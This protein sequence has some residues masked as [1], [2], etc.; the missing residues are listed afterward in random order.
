MAQRMVVEQGNPADGSLLAVLHP[1]LA[2]V[3]SQ[4]PSLSAWR[5]LAGVVEAFVK[6]CEPQEDLRHAEQTLAWEQLD[7]AAFWLGYAVVDARSAAA[8]WEVVRSLLQERYTQGDLSCAPLLQCA[9]ER[10]ERATEAA[11]AISAQVAA[12]CG[13]Y[14]LSLPERALG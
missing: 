8:R 4:E 13:Q 3:A 9:A 7:S 1:W 12:F 14:G 11:V 2:V 10:V 5:L 6:E